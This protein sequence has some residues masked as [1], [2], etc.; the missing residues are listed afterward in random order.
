MDTRIERDSMGE[1]EVPAKALYGAQTQ[2]AINNFPVSGTPMPVA[3]VHAVARIKLAAARSNH[4]LG[5]LDA[6][7]AQAIEKAAQAVID[8]QHDDHFPIDVFQ[9]GSGT[10]TNMNVNEVLATLA[11]REGVE[12]TPNDH[13]N[14]GQSSNDVIPTAIHLSAAIAV[15]E[16]LRPALTE[17]KA[18]IDRRANELSHVVKTGRTHL[19]DAMPLRMDQELGAWSSQVGQAI[20]RFDSAMT[21][22]CRLAQ[23]GTAVGTGINA[24]K[25]FAELMA[26]DLSQ[27]TGLSFAPNDSFFASLASQDAAVELSGQLKGFACVVMKIAN[28]LRWMNSGPLA[29]LGEIELEALQPGSSIMPGKVN[30]VIPESAAQAAAQ[31]MG[32]DTAITVA[33]Q[34][35]NFQ[36]NV[37]LPLVASNLL[38]SITL[39]SNTAKLLAER[40]IA[41][42]KV[43]EDNLQV[44][45]ARNPILVT[46]L[47][48]VI[49]YNAAA[50]IAK[51]AYQGG[52]PIIDV[53]EEETDLDRATL[54]RLLDPTV[55]TQGGVPE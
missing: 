38:T 44:P 34:S 52:R 27:Q 31:V 5:L 51:K 14:M 8:G 42:F 10:S 41:T 17:L 45:L 16:L 39:M 1:L 4:Q 18:T 53:A 33:G 55:L 43:R 19:M 50:A 24:P 26:K 12:V 48:S 35:G 36:L 25:G 49:G 7:R 21:R 40:A 47:N 30:P 6:E 28:D 32:L 15:N 3:F 13:V 23:G 22:L 11:S 46:A 54:E 9:T 29:G 20:E 37:M 2:R